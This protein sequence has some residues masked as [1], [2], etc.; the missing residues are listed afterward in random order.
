MKRTGSRPPARLLAIADAGLLE[1]RLPEAVMQ[2]ARGGLRWFLLRARNLPPDRVAGL[3]G[4]ILAVAP[5]IF[6]SVHGTCFQAASGIHFPSHRIGECVDAPEGMCAGASCHTRAELA[7]A[8]DSGADYAFLSP[9]YDPAS[10]P[11]RGAPLGAEGFK[12]VVTDIETPVFAL[13][14]VAPEKLRE[15]RDAGAYGAAVLGG[16]FLAPDITARAKE[17]A[18]AALEVFGGT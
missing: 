9:F 10:K 1:D 17:Y 12:R 11:G 5:D 2:A 15:V 3:A 18:E 7:L 6:L 16:L 14:G 4:E 13:G 8:A